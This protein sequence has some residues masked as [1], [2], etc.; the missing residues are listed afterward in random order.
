MIQHITKAVW[1]SLHMLYVVR[2]DCLVY[3]EIIEETFCHCDVHNWRSALSTKSR[4][5][6]PKGPVRPSCQCQEK[7]SKKRELRKVFLLFKCRLLTRSGSLQKKPS[8][9]TL[10]RWLK[11][12]SHRWTLTQSLLTYFSSHKLIQVFLRVQMLELTHPQIWTAH[13]TNSNMYVQLSDNF[14]CGCWCFSA[15]RCTLARQVRWWWSK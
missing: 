14:S 11:V 3:N 12:L 7:S 10:L 9:N 1:Y 15:L 6:F 4:V 8:I 13:E 2:I 5:F